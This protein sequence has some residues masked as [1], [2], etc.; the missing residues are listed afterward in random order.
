MKVTLLKTKGKRKTLTGIE[1]TALIEIMTH[2]GNEPEYDRKDSDMTSHILFA[3]SFRNRAGMQEMTTYN[4]IVML[5]VN[6]LSGHREAALIKQ[7]AADMPQTLVSFSGRDG[8]NVIILSTFARPDGSLPQT[9]KDIETFHAHA[10]RMAVKCYQPQLSR[11]IEMQE[12]PPEAEC[13]LSYDA[14]LYF[15]PNALP[16]RLRQPLAM[17]EETR[18]EEGREE[19]SFHESQLLQGYNDLK[20]FSLLYDT[21]YYEARQACTEETGTGKDNKPFLIRLASNCFQS[22]IPEEEAVR[23]TMF[24]LDREVTEQEIRLTLRNVYESANGFGKKLCIPA[25]LLLSIRT[26]DFMKRRYQFRHNTLTSDVEYRERHTFN[27]AFRPISNRVLNSI[28]LNAQAEGLQLWDRDVRRYVYSDR[29]PMYY[30]LFDYLN[31]F[32]KWDKRD[33]IRELADSVPCDNPHWRDLFYRW[34]LSM[35]AHWRQPN[36]QYANSTSPILV[37]PQGCGKSTFCRNLLPP[38]LKMY[39][40]DSIDFSRKR[41]AEMYLNRFALINM[42]EFDQ[43]S[44]SQQGFLKHILQKPVVNIRKPYQAAVQELTRIASFIGTSNHMDLL[45]DTTGNRRFICVEITGTIN[46]KKKIAYEQLYAQAIYALDNNERYWFTEM[47][48]ALLHKN[49]SAFEQIPA[50]EQLFHQH[51]RTAKGDEAYEELLAVEILDRLQKKSG[52]KISQS[53]IG[54]FGRCLVKNKIPQR[55]SSRGVLYKIVERAE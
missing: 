53:K 7:Q 38:E 9:P 50:I 24:Y 37:G 40:T 19:E 12:T 55:R 31:G 25:D 47:E 41:D 21:S 4:G 46:R 2:T 28:A 15:E 52:I 51:Y 26:H 33:R 34:F 23:W 6:G 5:N 44:I 32:P 35:V 48:E 10:Y 49:N 14:Q 43:I 54:Y 39:Y 13:P 1:L 3:G 36:R 27:F 18:Y 16:F 22:G 20:A 29:V 45:S 42:D 30:P 17:P 8:K 11:K